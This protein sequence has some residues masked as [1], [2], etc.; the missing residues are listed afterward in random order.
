[1][2]L[3]ADPQ[4]R[5]FAAIELSPAWQAALAS[6][7]SELKPRLSAGAVRWTRPDGVHLTLKFYGEVPP[8]MVTPVEESLRPAAAAGRAFELQLGRLGIF[9]SPRAP[10]VLWTGVTGGV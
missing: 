7:V 2:T 1:M 5:L 8:E 9:P 10:R 4:I 3:T 6:L